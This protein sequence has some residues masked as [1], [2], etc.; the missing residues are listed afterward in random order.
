MP[1][2]P[3]CDNSDAAFSQP[4]PIQQENLGRDRIKAILESLAFDQIDSRHD[5]I[6]R[7]Y[8]KT[9][10]WLLTTPE[11]RAW[12]NPNKLDE[13]HGFLW[14]KGNPGAGKST[15]MKFVLQ[16]AQKSKQSKCIAFFFNAL[17]VDLEKST[18]GMY[19]SLL[20]QVLEKIPRLQVV[21]N[22]LRIRNSNISQW[23]MESLQSLFEQAIENLGK[24]PLTCFIDALDECDDAQIKEMVSFFEEL[25]ETVVSRNI[26]FRV[27]LSSRHY[28]HITIAKGL[29]LDLGEQQGHNQDIV[30][31]VNGK[32]KI[33]DSKLAQR[34][35]KGLIEKASGV[36]I[37]VVLVI[38]ILQQEHDDGHTHMLLQRLNEIPKDLNSLFRDILTRDSRHKA[39]VLLCIQWVL[40]ARHPLRH[41]QLYVA[42][43][44]GIDP[45]AMPHL[46]SDAIGEADLNRFILSS[47]KGLL[48]ISSSMKSSRV[49]FIH[50]SVREFFFKEDLT[51]LWPKLNGNFR[52]ESHER[53]KQC[54]HSYMKLGVTYLSSR[55]QSSGLSNPLAIRNKFPLLAY[56]FRNI[57]NHAEESA[58]SGIDQTNFLESFNLHAWLQCESIFE[59]SA[60]CR[61]HPNT[62]LLYILA[63]SNAA[64]LIG[65]HRDKLCGF[66][67]EEDTP[68][69][70]PILAAIATNSR[71][72]VYAML[73][74]QADTESSTSILHQL[75]EDYAQ[76]KGRRAFTLRQFKLLKE[77][78]LLANLYATGENLVVS[79]LLTTP[80]AMNL[81]ITRS[82]EISTTLLCEAAESGRENLVR[83]LLRQDVDI[84]GFHNLRAM[85][86]L[87]LAICQ[88]HDEIV[89]LLLDNNASIEMAHDLIGLRPLHL[90]CERGSEAIARLLLSH[91]ADVNARCGTNNYTPL[92]CAVGY[93]TIVQLLLDYKAQTEIEGCQGNTPLFTA[94]EQG[95]VGTIQ[96]LLN[97]G[98]NIEA[99]NK[100]G[101]TPLTAIVLSS[102]YWTM[103]LQKKASVQLLLNRG[104]S[105][106]ALDKDGNTPLSLAKSLPDD[107]L[108]KSLILAKHDERLSTNSFF[109]SKQ[110]RES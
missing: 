93:G 80:H 2:S 70:T 97:N 5:T 107:D 57:L 78:D 34:V 25:A 20:L 36:F 53:L 9:C 29:I 30:K 40:F 43:R 62:S 89:R 65:Y 96:I 32:L 21:L 86:A 84:D 12:L 27:C 38:G 3:R 35:R 13:H 7:A 55:A 105:I 64:S 31:Y 99:V 79:F 23:S 56:T 94:A 17:G 15:I 6:N 16:T 106:H 108:I 44:I 100:M 92:H 83:Q 14:I 77:K 47:S 54:C 63:E 49:Q 91:G 76:R 37:W 50:E 103:T 4:S 87:Q 39:E 60:T 33:N 8:G 48:E 69:R 81:N 104:A 22:S 10:E 28:P 58:A 11:Y 75:C 52:G 42:I 71:Q 68:Y 1:K 46:G 61:H 90:A 101:H 82:R 59:Q 72:A 98:A 18:I 102:K 66:Q 73:K 74:A 109:H 88:N 51:K 110:F 85:T 26:L 19:R 67:E 24:T 45:S 41:E 95:R